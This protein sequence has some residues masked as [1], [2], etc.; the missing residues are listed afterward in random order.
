MGSPCPG[1]TRDRSQFPRS[2]LH[3]EVT[4]FAA[5]FAVYRRSARITGHSPGIGLG[6]SCR[7][8]GSYRVPPRIEMPSPRIT[9]ASPR[10]KIEINGRPTSHKTWHDS[11]VA[12]LRSPL[13]QRQ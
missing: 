4:S 1:T 10:E 11:S 5:Y 12:T 7:Q 3:V 9:G 8:F 2:R 13:S 6:K